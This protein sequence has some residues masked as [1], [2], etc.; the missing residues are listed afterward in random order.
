MK[1]IILLLLITSAIFAQATTTPL[2]NKVDGKYTLYKDATGNYRSQAVHITNDSTVPVFMSSTSTNP[3]I[4]SKDSLVNKDTVNYN[5]NFGYLKAYVSLYN[6]SG[7]TA[8]TVAFEHYSPTKVGWINQAIGFRDVLTDYLEA[9]N[10]L[11]IVPAATTKTFEI[12]MYRPG[13]VRIRTL[14]TRTR[15]SDV[16]FTGIN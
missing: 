8:D 6:R 15:T 7:S 13:N 3:R 2:A 10:L 1:Q 14:S 9:N 16:G 11:I 5:F 4:F 12:N